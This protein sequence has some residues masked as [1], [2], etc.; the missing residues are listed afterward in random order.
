MML[1]AL[2]ADLS[3]E[4]AGRGGRGGGLLDLVVGWAVNCG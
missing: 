4:A 1:R 2:P 3:A